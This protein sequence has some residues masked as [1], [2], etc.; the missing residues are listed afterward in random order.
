MP[1][2]TKLSYFFDHEKH[3]SDHRG[4]SINHQWFCVQVKN[5]GQNEPK[6]V[7]MSLMSISESNKI[8]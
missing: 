2:G 3:S 7:K 5:L 4:N 8:S 1:N 6:G